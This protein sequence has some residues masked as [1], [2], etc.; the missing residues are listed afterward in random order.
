M[1]LSSSIR[2]GAVAAL[3]GIAFTLPAVA[4]VVISSKDSA[5]IPTPVGMQGAP[6]SFT[7]GLFSQNLTASVANIARSPWDT[8]PTPNAFFSSVSGGG[9]ATYNFSGDPT[10]L[11][12]LWGSPD[13][14]N[15]LYFFL[16]DLQVGYFT[17]ANVIPPA[18]AGAGYV[19]V[20]FTGAFDK[21][22]FASGTNA[23]EYAIQA[24]PEPGSLALLGL[25]LAG[26]A[27]ASRR[28]Q[29]QA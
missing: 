29:K 27:A 8:T 17:G 13:L 7:A 3:T 12:L 11:S 1:N 24:V 21:V 9:S 20:V 28:K 5:V 15:D 16:D 2:L 22:V 10:S 6:A 26:L 19:N 23:F 14:Y 25:G 18:T 4:G